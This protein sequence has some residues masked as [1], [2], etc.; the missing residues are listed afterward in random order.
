MAQP[1]MHFKQE[2]SAPFDLLAA[3][4][5]VAR[6]TAL[7]SHDIDDAPELRQV[8]RQLAPDRDALDARRIFDAIT[9][10][11]RQVAKLLVS[12]GCE[13]DQDIAIAMGISI[14]GVHRRM[15]ELFDAAGVDSRVA[16]VLHI[17]R[18]PAL[19]ALLAAVAV[20]PAQHRGRSKE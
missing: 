18:W 4:A 20:T 12:G 6:Q 16:L 10:C 11:A 8:H 7:L 15:R 2:A 17:V 3:Q 13:R 19:E 1:E 5:E 9:P 14:N